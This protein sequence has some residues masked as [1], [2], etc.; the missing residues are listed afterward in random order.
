MSKLDLFRP[1]RFLIN[2]ALRKEAAKLREHIN[3]YQAKYD[4]HYQ[5][6]NEEIEQTK[7]QLD[8][9]YQASK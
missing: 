9:E 2:P 8:R 4:A 6:C 5:K 1:H 7:Q 3:E